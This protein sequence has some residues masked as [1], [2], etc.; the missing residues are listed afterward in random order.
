MQYDEFGGQL[1]R[2]RWLRRMWTGGVGNITGKLSRQVTVGIGGEWGVY[3][4][5]LNVT[6]NLV[7]LLTTY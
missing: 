6:N 1:R 7:L 2:T 4:N 5:K 3:Y